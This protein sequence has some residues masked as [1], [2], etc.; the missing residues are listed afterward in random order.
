[1]K[2]LGYLIAGI[3]ITVLFFILSC[4]DSFNIW[5]QMYFSLAATEHC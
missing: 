2:H 5:E 3:V 4:S 1:M